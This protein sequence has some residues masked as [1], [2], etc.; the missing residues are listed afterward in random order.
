[1]TSSR[2]TPRVRTV[3]QAR[4]EA[5]VLGKLGPNGRKLCLC[6]TELPKYRQSW[7]SNKCWEEFHWVTLRNVIFRRD[8]GVCAECGLDTLALKRDYD[9]LTL[10]H[11]PGHAKFYDQPAR[12]EFLK[13]H[14]IPPG[15][16]CSD[17]W[18]A[19]HIVPLIEGGAN[20]PE[21]LRTLCIPCH[22]KATAELHKRLKQQ[23]IDT[24]LKSPGKPTFGNPQQIE[25]RNYLRRNG[26]KVVTA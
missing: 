10:P 11:E 5:G 25:A 21:N 12:R 14:G 3:E 7:C 16:S 20:K 2:H 24:A 8:K 4:R 9:A 17:W 22:Q 15:R 1:M 23:R 6:G 19:D 18:D 13:D 26:R